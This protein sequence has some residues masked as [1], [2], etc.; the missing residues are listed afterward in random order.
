MT[1]N[2]VEESSMEHHSF[3]DPTGFKPVDVGQRMRQLR[4]E[5]GL[6]IKELAEKSGLAVNTLSL[7][8]NQ[9]TSPSVTTLEATAKAMGIA[10][11]LFFEPTQESEQVIFTKDGQRREMEIDGILVE[12]CGVDLQDHPMQPFHVTLPAGKGSGSDP[13]VHSGYELVCVH[14]G[15]I[16]YIVKDKTYTIQAGDSLL[17]DARLPHHWENKG[18]VPV[19]YLLVLVPGDESNVLGEGHF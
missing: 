15:E 16:E 10:V 19:V 2:T 14:S 11:A 7:I 8:E 4:K 1:D 3:F 18:E 6:S 9:K 5:R 12:D 17:F 13:I